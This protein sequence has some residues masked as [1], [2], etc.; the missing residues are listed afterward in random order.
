MGRASQF[1]LEVGL[2]GINVAPAG[3]MTAVA[4]ADRLILLP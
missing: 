4:V 1:G 3:Q 2:Q